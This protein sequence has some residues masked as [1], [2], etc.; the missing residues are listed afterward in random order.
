ML[1]NISFITAISFLAGC[2]HSPT[3]M[4]IPALPVTQEPNTPFVFKPQYQATRVGIDQQKI[5]HHS[6]FATIVS[7]EE[8]VFA[9]RKQLINRPVEASELH[10]PLK[11]STETVSYIQPPA[12]TEDD[13]KTPIN[14]APSLG[15][16][17]SN[18]STPEGTCATIACIDG[19]ECGKI[20]VCDGQPCDVNKQYWYNC[21]GEQCQLTTEALGIMEAA[22]FTGSCNEFG[23]LYHCPTKTNCK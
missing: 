16:N 9:P 1:K 22:K 21:T 20:M 12:G 23:D 11:A 3:V 5:A 15:F 18:Q 6:D 17:G 19:S 4:E 7:E 2:S 8:Y 14:S 10:S 13:V